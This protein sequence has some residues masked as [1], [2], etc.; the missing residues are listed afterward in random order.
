[1]TQAKKNLNPGVQDGL[2]STGFCFARTIRSGRKSG[3]T[4]SDVQ[5]KTIGIVE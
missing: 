1:V 3:I 4:S 2:R 5:I